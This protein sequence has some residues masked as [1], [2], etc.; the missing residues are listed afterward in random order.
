[1]LVAVVPVKN[2]ALRL[3]K[4]LKNLLA[5]PVDLVV[6]VLNGCNDG[7]EQIIRDFPSRLVK[8][9]VFDDAL[10]IDIP[11][12]VGAIQAKK[13]GA[14]AVLFVDGDMDGDIIDVLRELARA[15]TTKEADLALTN[16]YPA[17][18][19]A[20]LSDLASYL[21]EIRLALNRELGLAQLIGPASPSHG[22]HAVSRK[23]LDQI[24]LRELAVPPVA[25]ALAA[26]QGLKVRV[27]ATIAHRHLGSPFRSPVHA[28]RIAETI[29]GDCL[30][31]IN[32][33][34]GLPRERSLN[35]VTYLGYHTERKFDL[36]EAF[37]LPEG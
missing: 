33:A 30:E 28:R 12:A 16:C 21:L 36:L 3:E 15:V 26:K 37:G 11:R 20:R 6:P 18:E 9:L 32:L 10:G 7:S 24:P 8:A 22:P 13:L 19:L 1:M 2:E 35:G 14:R 29:I 23:F 31:A 5:V 25:L 27:K 17:E 34:C 4:V